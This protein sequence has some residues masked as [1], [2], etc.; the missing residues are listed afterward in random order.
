MIGLDMSRFDGDVPGVMAL[1]DGFRTG[2]RS[3]VFTLS[4]LALF[5]TSERIFAVVVA[6]ANDGR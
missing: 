3:G 5:V 2:P 4:L 6:R 1:E